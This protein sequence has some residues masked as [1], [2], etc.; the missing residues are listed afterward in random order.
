MPGCVRGAGRNEQVRYD[1]Y[2]PSLHLN[3]REMEN[4]DGNKC[5]TVNDKSGEEQEHTM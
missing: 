2:L 5:V 4:K 1:S 3:G